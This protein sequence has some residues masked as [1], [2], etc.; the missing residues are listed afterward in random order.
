MFDQELN[1]VSQTLWSHEKI[2]DICSSL[3]YNRFV[4][5]EESKV[6]LVDEKTMSIEYVQIIEK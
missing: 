5:I 2:S 4:L 6:F 3:T 1:I